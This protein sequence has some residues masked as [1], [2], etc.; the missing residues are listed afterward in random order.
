[1]WNNLVLKLILLVGLINFINGDSAPRVVCYYDSRSSLKDGMLI[2]R[3]C[4]ELMVHSEQNYPYKLS[5][6]DSR[7]CAFFVN[8]IE[9]SEPFLRLASFW[10]NNDDGDEVNWRKSI[11]NVLSWWYLPLHGE[12]F[13]CCS[14]SSCIQK[15]STF[16][17]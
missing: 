6:Y 7:T 16:S 12:I 14:L 5:Q 1:M 9:S 8:G 11:K 13:S 4:R 10:Q 2:T 17:F 15:V 3:W